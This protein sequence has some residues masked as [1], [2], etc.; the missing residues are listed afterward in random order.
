V[1]T[2]VDEDRP[3]IG[4][5]FGHQLLAVA[6]G[7]SVERAAVG[8]RVG[9]QTYRVTRPQPWMVPAAEEFRLIASHQDQVIVP[10]EGA[11]VFAEGPGCPVAGMAYGSAISFQGHPEYTPE[12]SQLLTLDRWERIGDEE[13]RRGLASLDLGV[14][15][16]L[17]ADWI[18]E[19]VRRAATQRNVG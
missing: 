13:T 14:T 3:Y 17:T 10:P 5:C 19:F 16:G 1:R 18:V 6:L 15:Q 8:W 11:V 12:L 4:D 7:G 9:V 2:L